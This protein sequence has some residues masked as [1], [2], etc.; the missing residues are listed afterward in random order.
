M[1]TDADA[2][3]S[4]DWQADVLD[5]HLT[6]GVTIGDTPE[7]RGEALR[8]RL[9]REEI[10][11]LLDAISVRNL[12]AAADAIVD[13]IYVL[14]GTAVTWGIDLHPL[15]DAVHAANM[16]KV[17]GEIRA[18]GKVL[19]PRGWEAPNIAAIL[20]M[21]HWLPDVGVLAT[22]SINYDDL[23]DPLCDSPI[24]AGDVRPPTLYV[25]MIAFADGHKTITTKCQYCL[26]KMNA[27][28]RENMNDPAFAIPIV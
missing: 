15:W 9:I 8:A 22:R 23:Y 19:K 12:P 16:K 14:I 5:F 2:V 27:V 11:E 4:T 24:H 28:A 21:Q 20:R 13:S 7:I 6:F 17:G 25:V 26:D 18:D 1:R 3:R 10:T